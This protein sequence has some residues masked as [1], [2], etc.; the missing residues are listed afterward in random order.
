MDGRRSAGQPMQPSA[1]VAEASSI[2]A[3]TKAW[4]RLPLI[5]PWSA[6]Y[7]SENRP[8]GPH[9]DLVRSPPV[10]GADQV[11]LLVRSHGHQET[12]EGKGPFAHG[13]VPV[14]LA[15]PVGIPVD[16]QF[17]AEAARVAT[18]RGSSAGIAPRSA[19]S[20]RAPS[21]PASLGERC[22]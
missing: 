11:T 3:C 10:L 18:V 17:G 15:E 20:N 13:Q 22:Q 14:R 21:R 7:S 12:A 5:C 6:S 19:G 8:G 4:G 1:K 2:T 9:D 16:G